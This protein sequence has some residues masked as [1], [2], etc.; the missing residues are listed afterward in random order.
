M[1]RAKRR[2]RVERRHEQRLAGLRFLAALLALLVL[3]ILFSLTIWQEVQRLF[4]L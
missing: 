1:E 2:A 3:S 4:G